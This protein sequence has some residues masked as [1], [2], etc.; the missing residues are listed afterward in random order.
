M[1]IT[2]RFNI[3]V[4]DDSSYSAFL[5][6]F[7]LNYIQKLRNFDYFIY[8]PTSGEMADKKRTESLRKADSPD[9]T[10]ESECFL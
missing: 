10:I 5:L 4:Y 8:L 1:R 2:L 9:F 3:S 6:F 7:V